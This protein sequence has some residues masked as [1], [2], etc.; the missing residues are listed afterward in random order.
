MAC[1]RCRS[2]R[3]ASETG[4]ATS[5]MAPSPTAAAR[6]DLVSVRGSTSGQ[7]SR[8]ARVTQTAAIIV[9]MRWYDD[10]FNRGTFIV[11]FGD[12]HDHNRLRPLLERGAVFPS[13]NL[14]A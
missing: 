1:A 14:T 13:A 7:S 11:H 6:P 2:D 10:S 8:T 4:F 3:L 9:S 12:D 5:S